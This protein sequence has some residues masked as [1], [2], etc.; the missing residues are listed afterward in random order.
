MIPYSSRFSGWLPGGALRI[1]ALLVIPAATAVGADELV[2]E[3]AVL[4]LSQQADV[5]GREAGLLTELLVREGQ[6]VNAGDVLARLDDSAE[7]LACHRAAIELERIQKVAGNDIKVRL[8]KKELEIAESEWN[9]ARQ[10]AE[11]FDRSVTS[12]ELDRLRLS[13]ERA[14]LAVEQETTDVETA[15]LAVRISENELEAATERL[16]RRQITTPITGTVV[17]LQRRLGEWLEAGQPVARVIATD[18]LRAEGFLDADRVDRDLVGKKVHFACRQGEGPVARFA[19]HVVFVSPEVDPVNGQVRVWAEIDNRDHR[20]RPGLS[21]S[22]TI[23][24]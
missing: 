12:A 3:S 15:R 4:T 10:S 2:V 11:R 13:V 20:L 24:P 23:E 22:M 7:K 14:T 19:G 5:P 18:R 21:G 1:L 17:A 9:R 6:P 8:A 16:R